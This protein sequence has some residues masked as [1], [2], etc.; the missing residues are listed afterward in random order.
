M[1]AASEKTA[2][3]YQNRVGESGLE[4]L[5]SVQILEVAYLQEIR[6]R[7]ASGLGHAF[8]EVGIHGSLTH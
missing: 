1:F 3:P 2:F 8:L 7:L 5:A 4:I 6:G